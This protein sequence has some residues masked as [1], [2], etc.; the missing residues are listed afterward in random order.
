[1]ARNERIIE[2]S[3]IPGKEIQSKRNFTARWPIIVLMQGLV[4]IQ[5]FFVDI[6]LCI[7]AFFV[8][9]KQRFQKRLNTVNTSVTL[10]SIHTIPGTE[11][12][13]CLVQCGSLRIYMTTVRL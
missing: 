3:K 8:D 1:M 7:E 2:T 11:C 12:L 13:H 10:I 5:L 9:R 4:E 6:F